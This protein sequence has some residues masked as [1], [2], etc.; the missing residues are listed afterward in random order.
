MPANALGTLLDGLLCPRGTTRSTPALIFHF[1]EPPGALQTAHSRH[2]C[3]F[4]NARVMAVNFLQQRSR[5]P[6]T[7]RYGSRRK[8]AI[9]ALPA[10]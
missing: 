1:P 2:A 7:R 4:L 6:L 10:N 9:K 5:Q 8:G 3:L